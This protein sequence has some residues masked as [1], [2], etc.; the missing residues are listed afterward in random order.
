[1]ANSTVSFV[2]AAYWITIFLFLS[3]C[4]NRKCSCDEQNSGPLFIK[5]WRA[6]QV[7][8]G[9]GGH[10]TA[11]TP[12]SQP[13]KKGM[14]IKHITQFLAIVWLILIHNNSSL[15]TPKQHRV[16]LSSISWRGFLTSKPSK[17]SHRRHVTT[18]NKG[19]TWLTVTAYCAKCQIATF[20]RTFYHLPFV[21]Y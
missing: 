15:C 3:K 2:H 9:N 10:L 16:V 17:S 11:I 21:K 13:M 6:I 1:M 20:A 19:T 18:T 8:E 7:T 14:W 12:T 4:E 5:R